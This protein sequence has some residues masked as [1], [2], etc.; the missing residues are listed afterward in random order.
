M[1]FK[2]SVRPLRQRRSDHRGKDSGRPRQRLNLALPPTHS[3][4]KKMIISTNKGGL[5]NRIKS[6]VSCL[7]YGYENNIEPKL[8]WEILNLY[9]TNRHILN[10]SFSKLFSNDFEVSSFKKTD[11]IYFS[12]CLMIFDSDN[13]P[14]NFDTYDKKNAKYTPNDKRREI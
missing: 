1:K 12:H 14:D 2:C 10:C 8:Y 5:S 3:P 4:C 13:L 11:K 9:K 6:L 7:R